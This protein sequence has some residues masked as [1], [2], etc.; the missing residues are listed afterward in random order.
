MDEKLRTF[1]LIVSAHPYYAR[2]F[3]RHVM[4]ERALSNFKNEQMKGQMAIA[5]AL[6]RFNGLR[7][8]AVIL[9]FPPESGF[10][11]NFLHVVQK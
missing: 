9:T 11:Y 10:I 5:I 6:P 1:E 4:H 8:S 3:T 7:R 2:K